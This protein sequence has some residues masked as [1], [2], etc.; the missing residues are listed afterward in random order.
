MERGARRYQV[1]LKSENGQPIDVFLISEEQNGRSASSSPMGPGSMS[2]AAAGADIASQL[3]S[4]PD[5]HHSASPT[6]APTS[7]STGIST[8]V[9]AAAA[10]LMS[11]PRSAAAAGITFSSPP[12]IGSDPFVA[13]ASA[14]NA[15]AS[16]L[17]DDDDD[18]G[19]SALG[20]RG[21]SEIDNDTGA[22]DEMRLDALTP[23]S[24]ID[25]AA[26]GTLQPD[27]LLGA[28]DLNEG[29]TDFFS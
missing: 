22:N 29:L 14:A 21:A 7:S 15:K 26:F 11:P 17:D 19:S 6:H 27:Y 10:V 1:F 28:L 13:N 25:P 18:I 3:G 2:S 24:G 12:R 9:D 8:D 20:K 16:S 5:A 4:T 23:K